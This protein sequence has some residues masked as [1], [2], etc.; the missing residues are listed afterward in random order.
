MRLAAQLAGF[1]PVRSRLV[2][3]GCV[4]SV[5][6]LIA[7]SNADTARCALLAVAGLSYDETAREQLGQLNE[8]QRRVGKEAPIVAA[9]SDGAPIDEASLDAKLD[10][11]LKAQLAA[12]NAL[13]LE[14]IRASQGGSRLCVLQ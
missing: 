9:A 10:E 4:N 11:K 14:Q 5:T 6:P 1:A 8:Q 7:D 2:L 3:L 12:N 13:L